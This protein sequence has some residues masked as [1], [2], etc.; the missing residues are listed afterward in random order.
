MILHLDTEILF[1]HKLCNFTMSRRL[2]SSCVICCNLITGKL[3]FLASV[4]Q[5]IERQP[6]N[7]RVAG[8]IPSQDMCLGCRPGPL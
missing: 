7:Q 2:P 5:R 8:L 1:I 3:N 4:A 6:A